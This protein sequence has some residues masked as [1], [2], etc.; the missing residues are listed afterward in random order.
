MPA[1]SALEGVSQDKVVANPSVHWFAT[2]WPY[3]TWGKGVP[4]ATE[5]PSPPS[6]ATGVQTPIARTRAVKHP[7]REAL[8]RVGLMILGMAEVGSVEV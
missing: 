8:L 6:L 3:E 4:L 7:S 2:S 5:A 1:S